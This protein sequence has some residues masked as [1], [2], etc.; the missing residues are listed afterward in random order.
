ML[1]RPQSSLSQNES[2]M[3]EKLQPTVTYLQ[4][5]GEEYM[6]QVFRSARWVFQQDQNIA[7]EVRPM[8]P[9]V[10]A[11]TCTLNLS[12]CRSSSLRM[13]NSLDPKLRTF[14]KPL[15]LGSVPGSLSISSK[16][17][18]KIPLFSIIDLQSCTLRWRL[19]VE[20]HSLKVLQPLRRSDLD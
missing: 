19:R 11:M 4:K 17:R 10:L 2:D 12:L 7:F 5:L 9:P 6:D 16:R 13:L 14:S 1:P 20:V 15:T 8:S 3:R 18:E